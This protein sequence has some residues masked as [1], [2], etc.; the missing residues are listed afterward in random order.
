MK[1]CSEQVDGPS[2]VSSNG[3]GANTIEESSQRNDMLETIEESPFLND[4]Y[5][6]KRR[7]HPSFSSNGKSRNDSL[8]LTDHFELNYKQNWYDSE[9]SELEQIAQATI[10][11]RTIASCSCL[12]NR[13]RNRYHDIVPFDSTRV[14]LDKPLATNDD[15]D[16]SDYINASFITDYVPLG[17]EMNGSEIQAPPPAR[18]PSENLRRQNSRLS[19]TRQQSTIS[20]GL[21]LPVKV[22]AK[23][24]PARYIAAQGPDEATIPLFWE[25]IWQQNVRVIVMLTSLV[26]GNSFGG[27]KAKC[28]LYWPS[29][30]GSVRRY[31]DLEVQLY[32]VQEAPDYTVRKFDVSKRVR[33]RSS[34]TACCGGNRE[35]VHIQY[36]SWP[37]R[38]APEEPEKLLQLIELTRILADQYMYRCENT[39]SISSIKPAEKTMMYPSTLDIADENNTSNYY[40]SVK[41]RHVSGGQWLVHCSA[42]VGRTG[43]LNNHKARFIIL[44][45]IYWSHYYL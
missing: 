17:I 24:S 41:K 45:L 3:H 16:P 33:H 40:S 43:K 38:S 11:R 1:T 25:M 7:M 21:G 44:K 13:R 39:L 14:K 26:E 2:F 30:V 20:N 10:Q 34:E 8:A 31:N 6:T 23:E 37:D 18:R 27:S 15:S 32:D 4:Q 36:T 28:S 42:G 19:Y 9:F 12:V 22:D 35:I 5:K 29:V